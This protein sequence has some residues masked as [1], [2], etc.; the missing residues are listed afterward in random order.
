M[1]VWEFSYAIQDGTVVDGTLIAEAETEWEAAASAATLIAD[2]PDVSLSRPGIKA[3]PEVEARW[4][5]VV[6][7]PTVV[8]NAGRFAR[9]ARGL[10]PT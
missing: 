8:S 2:K 5:E 6:D 4:R 10:P 1:S 3:P 7:F 9:Y